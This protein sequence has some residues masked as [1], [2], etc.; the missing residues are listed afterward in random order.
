MTALNK[1]GVITYESLF[2][3]DDSNAGGNFDIATGE[4]HVGATGLYLVTASL[5][6]RTEGGRSQIVWL[7]VDGNKVEESSTE[8][9]FDGTNY[10]EIT[11]NTNRALVVH[12]KTGQT[13]RLFHQMDQ[14]AGVN[15]VTFCLSSI[16]LE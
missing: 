14:G 15:Y 13:A 16:K 2:S 4:F 6:L 8:H 9:S 3:E 1:Q 10:G 11:D 12:L 7:E 5:D